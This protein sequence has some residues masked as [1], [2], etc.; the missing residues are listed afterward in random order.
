MP[1]SPSH[2]PFEKR[3]ALTRTPEAMLRFMDLDQAS[4]TSSTA[5]GDLYKQIIGGSNGLTDQT[6]LSTLI[7]SALDDGFSGTGQ[8]DQAGP[9][10]LSRLALNASSSSDRECDQSWWQAVCSNAML[11]NVIPAIPAVSCKRT[12]N[13]RQ[14]RSSTPVVN[15]RAKNTVLESISHLKHVKR[16]HRKLAVLRRDGSDLQGET[17][18][19]S[20]E[21]TDEEKAESQVRSA[22][23]RRL[24]ETLALGDTSSRHAQ[25][26]MQH[27]CATMLEYAG[28]D[29]KRETPILQADFSSRLASSRP[30]VRTRKYFQ[31][32]CSAYNLAW[33]SS[34]IPPG[35]ARSPPAYRGT[36]PLYI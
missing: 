3:P 34:C 7:T 35:Y 33:A 18:V 4:Q 20:D 26:L 8:G 11:S 29:C 31:S 13:S 2:I 27:F 16:A 6:A 24:E 25:R 22:P 1:P 12:R 32:G 5:S 21:A 17:T 28:F 15:K 10:N 9:S 23:V 19:E 14:V 30:K 36:H